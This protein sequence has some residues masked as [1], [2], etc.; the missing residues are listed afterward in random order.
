[1]MYPKANPRLKESVAFISD[2]NSLPERNAAWDITGI[3]NKAT[4]KFF[5]SSPP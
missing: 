1:M 4:S 3:N 2:N 5:I